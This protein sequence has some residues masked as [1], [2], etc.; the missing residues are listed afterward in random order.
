MIAL[1]DTE[2][3]HLAMLA[4]A[5]VAVLALFW[6]F[7][8]RYQQNLIAQTRERMRKLAMELVTNRNLAENWERYQERLAATSNQLRQLEANLPS[9]DVLRW[10]WRTFSNPRT[11]GVTVVSIEPPKLLEPLTPNSTNYHTVSFAMSGK[12]AYH[13]FGRFLADTENQFIHARVQHLEL[14]PT[15]P[16][17]LDN[18]EARKLLF[19]LEL[20]IL[21]VSEPPKAALGE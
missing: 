8:I 17:A 3:R 20:I 11:K 12:A 4:V 1:T 16:D 9:G 2:K 13:D 7:V 19:R 21:S 6:Q 10:E 5:T 15:M 14:E 18:A